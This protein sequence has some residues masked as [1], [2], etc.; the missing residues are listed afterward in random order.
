MAVKFE[1]YS[2]KVKAA[3]NSTTIQWLYETATDIASEAKQTASGGDDAMNQVRRSYAYTVD[4]SKGE[5]KVGNPLEGAYWEE[6]GT[7]EY[8]DT[9]KNGGRKG[10]AGYWI[11]SRGQP[12]MGGGK[13]YKTKQ[14]AYDMAAYI[15]AK[16]R[17]SAVVTSGRKPNY[18]LEKAFDHVR[19]NA[20]ANLNDDLKEMEKRK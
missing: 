16:Y 6:F 18:T 11:Y 13:T 8:A 17:K 12:S 10:R 7:G 20:I 1:D 15:R 9:S 2:I 5:A 14:E 4:E 3:L 19:P